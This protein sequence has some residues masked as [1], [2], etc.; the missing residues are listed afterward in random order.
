MGKVFEKIYQLV[1]LIPKGRVTTYGEIAKK[2]KIN[3]RVVGFALHQNKNPKIPCHRVVSKNGK[4][5][6][7]YS[8]GGWKRQRE[9]L[10]AE[11]LKFKNKTQ[12]I[13][14]IK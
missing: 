10:I 6:K 13:L 5:A 11:G 9:R 3:P 4:I 7:N 1:K 14:N 8:M 12:V 2:L